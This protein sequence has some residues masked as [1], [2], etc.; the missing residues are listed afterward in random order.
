MYMR[1]MWRVGRVGGGGRLAYHDNPEGMGGV[2]S[3]SHRASHTKWLVGRD[4]SV[5]VRPRG[6]NRLR[7]DTMARRRDPGYVTRDVVY[8]F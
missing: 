6:H 7:R 8:P 1:Y 2:L 5:G 4:V 3:E